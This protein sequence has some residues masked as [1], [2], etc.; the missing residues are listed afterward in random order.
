[1][2]LLEYIVKKCIVAVFAIVLNS[3]APAHAV[4]PMSVTTNAYQL[5]VIMTNGQKVIV[6]HDTV[7]IRRVS[8]K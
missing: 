1:M 7:M 4:R 3:C 2:F 8:F 5:V 6:S